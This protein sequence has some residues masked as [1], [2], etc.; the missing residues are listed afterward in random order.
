MPRRRKWLRSRVGSTG[1]GSTPSDAGTSGPDSGRTKREAEAR[2]WP[3]WQGAEFLGKNPTS[4]PK[5]WALWAGM[6]GDGD[7]PNRALNPL[8]ATTAAPWSIAARRTA[9]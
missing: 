3:R 4:K 8:P 7:A 6:T 2:A 1:D 9:F 5:E